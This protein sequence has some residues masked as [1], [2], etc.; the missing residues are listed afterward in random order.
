MTLNLYS[1]E[2][3][4]KIEKIDS[5]EII[6][7][8]IA[9]RKKKIM[10]KMLGKLVGLVLYVALVLYIT[11]WGYLMMPTFQRLANEVKNELNLVIDTSEINNKSSEL[12]NI[13]EFEYMDDDEKLF[14]EYAAG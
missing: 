8:I 1:F 13:K 2:T 11:Y 5:K 14:A 12:N 6:A 4:F 7:W 3:Q 9:Q 10:Q